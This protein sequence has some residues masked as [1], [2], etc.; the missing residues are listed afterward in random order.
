MSG[1]PGGRL[2][3]TS[4]RTHRTLGGPI[5]GPFRRVVGGTDGQR[6]PRS[7][8]STGALGDG[9]PYLVGDNPPPAVGTGRIGARG[10]V[11]VVPVSERG[12]LQ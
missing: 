5:G 10:K 8:I 11:D 7:P 1:E 9:V 12:G 6:T 3:A 4:K 2:G